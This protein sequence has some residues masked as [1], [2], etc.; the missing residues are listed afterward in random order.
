MNISS[1]TSKIDPHCGLVGVIG[2]NVVGATKMIRVTPSCD[3]GK[4]ESA[5]VILWDWSRPCLSNIV[6]SKSD[7]SI[8]E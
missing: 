8:V 3:I 1:I 6:P 4:I 5:E 2:Q 7:V